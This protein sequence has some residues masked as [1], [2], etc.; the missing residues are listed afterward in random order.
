MK[1]S[2]RDL[3]RYQRR[4]WAERHWRRWYFWATH[5]R[6]PPM[7]KAARTLRAHLPN[8]LTYFKHRITNAMSEGLNSKIGRASCRER[9]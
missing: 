2:L 7:I 8:I 9:V 5:S 1:E 3:W 6:L 4:A